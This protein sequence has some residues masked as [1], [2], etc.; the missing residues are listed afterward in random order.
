MIPSSSFLMIDL[1]SIVTIL[2]FIKAF[3]AH[4]LIENFNFI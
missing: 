2:T 1:L 3:Q 4:I